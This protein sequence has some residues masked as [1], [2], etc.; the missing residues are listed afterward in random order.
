MNLYE[1]DL[2]DKEFFIN[3]AISTNLVIL[4]ATPTLS[5]EF[6][7][8]YK[9]GHKERSFISVSV[10]DL[11]R[12][13]NRKK[14]QVMIEY[15]GFI[16]YDVKSVMNRLVN[17][18]NGKF[19]NVYEGHLSSQDIIL[20]ATINEHLS[21]D[22]CIHNGCYYQDACGYCDKCHKY[23]NHSYVDCTRDIENSE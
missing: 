16:V 22:G 12:G 17:F 9:Q 1:S 23:S 15:P 4:C 21:C 19:V 14:N 5:S 7:L 8:L 18:A 11:I 13:R 6:N 2:G 20:D 3:R 10:D